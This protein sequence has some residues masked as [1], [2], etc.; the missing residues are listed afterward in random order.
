MAEKTCIK[1]NSNMN[2]IHLFAGDINV[3]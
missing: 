2:G 1:K 3:T